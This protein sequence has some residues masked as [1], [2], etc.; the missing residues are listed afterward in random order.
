MLDL[1]QTQGVVS[2]QIFWFVIVQKA[3]VLL[4][5]NRQ[6]IFFPASS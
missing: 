5:T 6:I 2:Q 1:Q 3:Q 4:P